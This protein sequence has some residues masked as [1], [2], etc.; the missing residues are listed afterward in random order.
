MLAF[1]LAVTS[2]SGSA[3]AVENLA[4]ISGKA[5]DD[6]QKGWTPKEISRAFNKLAVPADT[7]AQQPGAASTLRPDERRQCDF[8]Y[9]FQMGD[10]HLNFVADHAPRPPPG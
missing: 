3:E 8:G 7:Q 5:H 10:I 6:Q 1:D 4:R 2:K 9:C